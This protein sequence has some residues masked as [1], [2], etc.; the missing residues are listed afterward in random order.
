MGFFINHEKRHVDT[1]AQLR[2]VSC[3][4]P[5]L[6]THQLHRVIVTGKAPR[7]PNLLLL[8]AETAGEIVKMFH[9]IYSRPNHSDK[10][11]SPL[12]A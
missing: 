9:L 10:M 1:T 3:G 4:Q 5:P 12:L 11:D 8:P 6:Y 2:V 7:E